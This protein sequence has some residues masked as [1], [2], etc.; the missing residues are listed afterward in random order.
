MMRAAFVLLALVLAS[1]A[2]QGDAAIPDIDDEALLHRVADEQGEHTRELARLRAQHKLDLQRNEEQTAVQ[3]E[4][5][6]V[7]YTHLT[8]PTKA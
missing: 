1:S 8:L 5:T 2:Y 3:K 4:M 6:P 7:S